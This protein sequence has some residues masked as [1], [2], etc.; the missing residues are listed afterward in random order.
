M[1]S[2]Q[3]DTVKICLYDKG[4]YE[5]KDQLLINKCKFV[6]LKYCEYLNDMD[7]IYENIDEYNPNKKSKHW[8][9]L[10]IWLLKCVVTKT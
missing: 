6:A 5:A 4:L 7:D 8:L 2:H 1:L 10:K 3:P 9:Y